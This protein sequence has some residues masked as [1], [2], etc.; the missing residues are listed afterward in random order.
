MQTKLK[1]IYTEY[2]EHFGVEEGIEKAYE[3]GRI[4]GRIEQLRILHPEL[5]DWDKKIEGLGETT[6]FKK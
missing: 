2:A 6:T 3:M 4:D 1:K 5:S